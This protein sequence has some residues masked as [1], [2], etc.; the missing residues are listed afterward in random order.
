M[1]RIRYKLDEETGNLVAVKPI[2]CN[3]RFVTVSLDTKSM[4]FI[5]TDA[6]TNEV[7]TKQVAPTV[8][9]L[10]KQAKAYLV[11]LGA[12]FYDEVRNKNGERRLR[13]ES[14]NT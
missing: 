9:L 10:K 11:S 6:N 8:P 5:I 13:I 2:L 1:T 4:R 7:I 14:A 3:T 12:T